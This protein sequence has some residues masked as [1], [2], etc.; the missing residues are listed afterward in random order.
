MGTFRETLIGRDASH[1][2]LSD[3]SNSQDR[4]FK[5]LYKE[6][7]ESRGRVPESFSE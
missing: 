2:E 3:F 1:A 6:L 7:R 4:D 5:T